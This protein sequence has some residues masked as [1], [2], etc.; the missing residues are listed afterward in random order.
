LA[1]LLYAAV[2]FLYYVPFFVVSQ[3]WLLLVWGSWA[4]VTW[5]W[6]L[7]R[8]QCTRCYN[9]SCPVNRVPEEVRK[10]FFLNYTQFAKAWQE[11]EG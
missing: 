2:L 3:Q 4:L 8:T 1:C 6:I 5:V 10:G 11:N 7:Q 9:L